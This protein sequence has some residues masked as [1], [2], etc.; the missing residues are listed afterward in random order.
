MRRSVLIIAATAGAVAGPLALPEYAAANGTPACRA[1]RLSAAYTLDPFSQGA[2]N[3]SYTL[4][5]RNRS[6]THCVLSAPLSVKLL[7]RR[8]QAL[9]TRA[10]TSP[11]GRYRVTLRAGEWA[12]ADS[13]FSPDIQGPG[14][15]VPC[16]A[17][18]HSLRVAIGGAHIVAAMDPTPVCGHGAIGFRRLRAAGIEPAC[19]ASQLTATFKRAGGGTDYGLA[20]RNAGTAAC[21]LDGAPSL[22]LLASSGRALATHEVR[23]VPY[24]IVVGVHR[25]VSLLASFFSVSKGGRCG[26]KAAAVRIDP[27]PGGGRL[28]APLAPP[29]TVCHRGLMTVSG[30]LSGYPF[31]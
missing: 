18:A 8:G 15:G 26:P 11:G 12:Q 10:S 5:V 29:T 6:R 9:P 7:G 23:S 2:G 13:R 14:E 27:L 22:R 21:Y 25:E 17:T 31:G 19:K 30:L 24:P 20:L 16:E 4:T 28:T 1:A 3:V